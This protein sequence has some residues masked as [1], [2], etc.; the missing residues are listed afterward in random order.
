M[1][2]FGQP[3]HAGPQQSCATAHDEAKPPAEARLAVKPEGGPR[4]AV[5]SAAEARCDIEVVLLNE[6]YPFTGC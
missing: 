6:W 4:P 2:E 1:P 3:N 5:A